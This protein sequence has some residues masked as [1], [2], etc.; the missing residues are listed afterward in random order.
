VQQIAGPLPDSE[1]I[2]LDMPVNPADKPPSIA[3]RALE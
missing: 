2:P 1:V 3:R